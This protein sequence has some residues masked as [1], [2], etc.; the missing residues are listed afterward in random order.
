[1]KII[2]SNFLVVCSRFVFLGVSEAAWLSLELSD[3]FPNTDL[4]PS[5]L[6][7]KLQVDSDRGRSKHDRVGRETGAN[8]QDTTPPVQMCTG[9]VWEEK[10]N[11]G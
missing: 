11:T 1:M 8:K 3:H 7:G 10:M 9:G 2:S 5:V 4:S 6:C